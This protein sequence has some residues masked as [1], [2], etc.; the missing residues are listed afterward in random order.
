MVGNPQGSQVVNVFD[1]MIVKVIPSDRPVPVSHGQLL[2][3]HRAPTKLTTRTT[4]RVSQFQLEHD[5]I[6]LHILLSCWP[7]ELQYIEIS[8]LYSHYFAFIHVLVPWVPCQCQVLSTAGCFLGS[9]DIV[10]YSQ[11][12]SQTPA[13]DPS[14]LLPSGLL[15]FSCHVLAKMLQECLNTFNS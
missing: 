14:S 10:W 11:D 13:K 2:W 8:R 1:V 3:N 4:H 15:R 9:F 6:W 12:I 5:C 7:P